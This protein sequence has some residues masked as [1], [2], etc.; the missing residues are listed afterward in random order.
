MTGPDPDQ[1]ARARAFKLWLIE[2]AR[3]L[4]GGPGD[5]VLDPEYRRAYQRAFRAG[6]R[7]AKR[8]KG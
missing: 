4:G 8:S 3:G 6:W 1:A 2:R 7:A 5:L